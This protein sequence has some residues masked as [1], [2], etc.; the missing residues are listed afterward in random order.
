VNVAR[1]TRGIRRGGRCL[2]ATGDATGR[3]C[4]RYL[5][6]GTV[7]ARKPGRRLT[8]HLPSKLAKRL[9]GGRFRAAAVATD[10]AG[11]RS[12]PRTLT[13]RVAGEKRPRR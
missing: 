8:I 4:T 12:K 3:R 1:P 6:V 13:F 7:R 2:K 11:N 5:K 9:A 10:P